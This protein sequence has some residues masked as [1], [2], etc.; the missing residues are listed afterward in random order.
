MRNFHKIVYILLG[1][2]LKIYHAKQWDQ[3]QNASA[4]IITKIMIFYKEKE[5]N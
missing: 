3:L 5:V 4:I 1:I 2:T